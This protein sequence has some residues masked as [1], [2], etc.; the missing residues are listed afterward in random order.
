MRAAPALSVSSPTS[1]RLWG[2]RWKVFGLEKA[3]LGD[4]LDAFDEKEKVHTPPTLA[5]ESLDDD[6]GGFASVEAQADKMGD[7]VGG[8]GGFSSPT[9]QKLE[10]FYEQSKW[11]PLDYFT[12]ESELDFTAMDEFMVELLRALEEYG[13]RVVRVFP[14]DANVLVAFSDHFAN[15]VVGEYVTSLLTRACEISNEIFL[16]ATA[17][18]FKEV[19]RMVEVIMKVATAKDPQFS[20]TKAEEVVYR[21]FEP[22]MDKHLDE[23][24]EFVKQSFEMTCHAMEKTL[25]EHCVVANASPNAET[26][27]FLGSHNPAQVKRTVLASFT[28]VLLLPIT[29]VPH[30]VPAAGAAIT[31]TSSAAVQGIA[32]LD[33]WRWG[34]TSSNGANTAN[35][36]RTA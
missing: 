2:A 19:W 36:S 17:A 6:S 24:V 35:G 14:P 30:T 11:K 13:S 20:K 5:A 12:S 21:M 32:M 15:E 8:A 9:P 1:K 27:R 23:E 18:G 28:D 34:A 29:I 4:V 3:R 10:I 26:A 25:S 7:F 31:T 16:K 33:P 22:N